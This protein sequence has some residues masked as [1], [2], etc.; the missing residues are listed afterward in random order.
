MLQI[1]NNEQKMIFSP[2]ELVEYIRTTP[3]ARDWRR[4]GDLSS[5]REST[6]WNGNVTLEESLDL[7]EF[8]WEDGR[9]K[10][11]RAL[12]KLSID[13]DFPM[14][15]MNQPEMLQDVAGY[16][17][18][19][20][21]YS[22][23]DPACM[24]YWEDN[25]IETNKIVKIVVPLSRSSKASPGA[26]TNL[27]IALC[28]LI[29]KIESEG[30]K[31]ELLGV[32]KNVARN[33]IKPELI[34]RL[35]EPSQPLDIDLISFA[36]AHPAMLRR[37]KFAWMERQEGWAETYA[38][39]YGSPEDPEVDDNVFLSPRIRGESIYTEEKSEYTDY[40]WAT[41]F[42]NKS[43]SSVIKAVQMVERE[44]EEFI[45]FTERV[46]Q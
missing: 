38:W 32:A 33:S 36:I 19:M 23:G 35:K 39:S 17:T 34:I 14:V 1:D 40:T 25:E 7:F 37:I 24:N 16:R 27:G 41:Y 12:K 22:A 46:T 8:G 31:V 45:T 5:R 30:K 2:L 10:T 11:E 29:D 3:P 42:E 13:P 15:S 21:A 44:Y 9:K 6:K 18:D 4:F 28:A 43:F 20:G 26:I